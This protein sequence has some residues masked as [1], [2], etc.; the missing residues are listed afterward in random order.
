VT[1]KASK[2][3]R[4]GR[5]YVAE[6]LS[7]DERLS[8]AA[9]PA[10]WAGPAA[11]ALG[12]GP[13]LGGHR[14][15]AGAFLRVLD[16]LS[17]DGRKKLVRNAGSPTRLRAHELLLS[18]DKSIATVWACADDPTRVK[19]IDCFAA[20]CRAVLAELDKS[21]GFARTGAGGTGLVKAD[22][23]FAVIFHQTSR[24]QDPLPHFHIVRVNLGRCPDGK[25]RTLIS[26]DLFAAQRPLNGLMNLETANE[27]ER[28]LSL[29]VV[30]SGQACAIPGVPK[31]LLTEFST[32][33]EQIQ[34]HTRELGFKSPAA[35]QIAAY[36]TRPKKEFL[37]FKALLASWREAARRHRFDVSNLPRISL[38]E[39]TARALLPEPVRLD[40]VLLGAFKL[41]T[42]T[43]T[44]FGEQG[45][46]AAAYLA[47]VGKGVAP[48][49]VQEAVRSALE[50]PQAHGL[51]PAGTNKGE[52]LYH[53]TA[54]QTLE[55]RLDRLTRRYPTTRIAPTHAAALD[56]LMRVRRGGLPPEELAAVARL[57]LRR[58]GLVLLTGQELAARER[59]LRAVR[60]VYAHQGY[61]TECVSTSYAAA[62]TAFGDA[63]PAVGASF[64]LKTL[65]P[66]PWLRAHIDAFRETS[67]RDFGPRP[68][69]AEVLKHAEGVYRDRRRVKSLDARTVLLVHD[70]GRIPAADLAQ[71]LTH[72]RKGGAK[73]VLCD[74][75]AIRQ[76]SVSADLVRKLSG[77]YPTEVLGQPPSQ[78]R[79]ETAA[80]GPPRA[81]SRR[82]E[83]GLE[84]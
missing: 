29:K 74:D 12:L 63:T 42:R 2:I 36:A 41:L 64:F 26:R 84:Q 62:Q 9:G 60:D 30:L 19:I 76:P 39:S 25:W 16:G 45:L 75:P 70:A 18:P 57:M 40:R 23:L 24:A 78:V 33:R 47:A 35:N 31:T 66:R 80:A 48:G 21:C 5:Y 50:R 81:S 52:P 38:S 6:Q 1:V 77:L 43:G 20:G 54:Q 83:L 13:A 17:P 59:V 27:L 10:F 67:A 55:S 58:E 68:K 73:V 82:P 15:E 53:T 8:N 61:R 37:P 65:T 7:G 3:L 49:R 32:R 4:D 79:M 11:G 28:K 46:L 72:A 56:A 51:V 44:A 14:V 69:L 71:L 34:A 22:Q